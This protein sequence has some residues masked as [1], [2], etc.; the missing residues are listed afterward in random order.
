MIDAFFPASVR[1][2]ERFW[3]G[4]YLL[5][6]VFFPHEVSD[7]CPEVVIDIRDTISVRQPA[8]AVSALLGLGIG[9]YCGLRLWGMS[10]ND[11]T[12][13]GPASSLKLWALAFLFT[14]VFRL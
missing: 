1:Q 3:L 9:M 10:S 4:R 14:T 2:V 12:S 11:A 13:G 8:L 7:K 6:D 5:T